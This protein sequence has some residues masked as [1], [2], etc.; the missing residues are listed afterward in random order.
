[1][2]LMNPHARARARGASLSLNFAKPC[3]HFNASDVLYIDVTRSLR[4][5]RPA[6]NILKIDSFSDFDLIMLS[7][8]GDT[9]GWFF[10]IN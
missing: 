3:F 6:H 1:M 5:I 8:L 4:A 7:K 10:F 2:N 9:T